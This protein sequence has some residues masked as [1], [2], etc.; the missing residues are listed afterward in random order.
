[1][2]IQ[3]LNPSFIMFEQST[4]IINATIYKQY[5]G[6]QVEKEQVHYA[7]DV[8]ASAVKDEAK[9]QRTGQSKLLDVIGKDHEVIG[10]VIHTDDAGRNHTARFNFRPARVKQLTPKGYKTAPKKSTNKGDALKKLGNAFDK[11][12]GGEP[13]T[14]PKTTRKRTQTKNKTT[15]SKSKVK[16][17]PKKKTASKSKCTPKRKTTSKKR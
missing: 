5:V 2:I 16:S 7:F 4:I 6:G 8:P 13:Q 1:M 14:K 10:T 12:M 15:K 3:F 11:L 17:T 9:L